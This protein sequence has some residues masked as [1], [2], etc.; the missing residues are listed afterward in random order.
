MSISAS[1]G[2]TTAEARPSIFRR[3]L[4][5]R[6][7][8]IFIVVLIVAAGLRIASPNFLSQANLTALVLGLSFNAIAA[9]GMTVL[10]I[11]GGFDLSIGASLALAGAV[12]G[13]VMTKFGMPAPIGILAG[14]L[15]GAAVGLANGLIIAK[16]GVNPLIA[17]L[18]MQQVARG[19][20]FL[21][22]SGL[23]IPN[24]PDEFNVIAQGKLFT[25][26]YPVYIMLI[27]VIVGEILLRRWRFFRQSYFIG[28]NERSA[29]L[30]GINVDRVKIINYIL[31][32][33]LAALSGV[34]LTAR[35]GTASVSAGL[36][37][38]LQ[39]ISACVIGGASLAGGEGSV[40]GSLLG[41]ILMALI[42]N[43]LNLLGIN[44]YWQTIVIGGVLILTVAVDALNRRRSSSK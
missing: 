20:V 44:P 34:L 12:A 26:Q 9:V 30:S 17:T 19:I 21:L 29:R 3:L 39:V 4:E 1:K 14:L 24:L 22:T 7:L 15:A 2:A 42:L 36:G 8:S 37:V 40:L 41:V 5:Q 16:V 10:L 6:E 25:L 31:M 32:G 27:V 28:G 38:D 23:G 18:G 35:M 33:T 43:G 13:M 11:S